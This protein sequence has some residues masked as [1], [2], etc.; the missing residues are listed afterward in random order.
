MPDRP[1]DAAPPKPGSRRAKAVALDYKPTDDAPR[2]TA[3]GKGAV[4]ER[5]VAEAFA[6][7]VAVREDPDLVEILAAFDIGSTIPVEAFGAVAEILHYLYMANRAMTAR[8]PDFRPNPY[9]PS[10]AGPGGER[11]G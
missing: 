2:I 6:H 9:R 10:P 4:A 7:G 8:Q 3:T 5:I 11:R 1:A